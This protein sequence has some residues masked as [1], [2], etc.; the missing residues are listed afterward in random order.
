MRFVS[1]T[2]YTGQTLART[3]GAR[4]RRARAADTAAEAA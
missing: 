4:R 2:W 3:L 1:G